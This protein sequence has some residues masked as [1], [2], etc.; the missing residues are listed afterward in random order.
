M[1]ALLIGY[2]RCSTDPQDLTAQH[3]ALTVLGVSPAR[4]YVDHGLSGTNRERPGLRE[5]LA[6]CREGGTAA[7]GEQVPLAMARWRADLRTGF[8]DL[9]QLGFLA[10][11]GSAGI[12]A[13]AL[14]TTQLAVMHAFL[15]ARGA[16]LLVVSGHLGVADRGALRDAL[17]AAQVT[18]VR[19]CGRRRH[20]R[21]P[22]ARPCVRQRGPS[23]RRRPP[24]HRPGIPGRP[25]LRCPRRA[26]PSR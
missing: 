8:V 23:L 19:L 3:D 9:Q 13:A 24:R 21:G 14:A 20:P 18:V 26:G 11:P 15:A 1:A 7:S 17:P 5:A 10:A 22:R 25:G 2:A 4:I 6:A 16:G 12:T